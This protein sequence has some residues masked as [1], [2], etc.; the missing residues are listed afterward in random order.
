VVVEIVDD[1]VVGVT[2]I[3]NECSVETPRYPARM[4]RVW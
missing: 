2:S 3:L 4:Q 1:E